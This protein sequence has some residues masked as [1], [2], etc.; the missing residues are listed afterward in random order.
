MRTVDSLGCVFAA[1]LLAGAAPAFAA[2]AETYPSKP[3][4]LIVPFPPGGGNDFIGRFTAQ[5]MVTVLGQQVIVDNRP[6]AG[7]LIGIES[8]VNAPPDGYTLIL[9]SPSYTVN[10]ALY[11]LKFDPVNDI[12]A[13]VQISHG[14]LIIV[15]NPALPAKTVKELIALAKAKPGQINYASSGQGSIIHLAS[16]LFNTMAGI[17]MT[18]VPYKGGGPALNDTIGGQTNI[19]FATIPPAKPQIAAG[20]LRGL[21]VTTAKRTPSMPDTPTVAEAGV[22]G[23]DVTLWHGF[24]GP[25]KLP[26]SIVDRINSSVLNVVKQQDT[27]EKLAVEGF[28]P[29]G[30]TP[31]QFHGLIKREV[32]VWAKVVKDAGIK[33]Q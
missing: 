7:G 12:K 26:R 28:V 32:G 9:I 29:E 4:R 27:I 24:V 16:E 8:G 18:H 13:V 20:R 17:K 31:E 30:G 2:A 1:A 10:P 19:F 21:A 22:P 23:Y 15:T 14:P 25:K 5:R 33:Q 6:G 11:Q 3:I